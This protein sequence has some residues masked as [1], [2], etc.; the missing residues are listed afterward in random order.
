LCGVDCVVFVG[1]VVDVGEAL[2]AV[3]VGAAGR[4]CEILDVGMQYGAVSVSEDRRECWLVVR[5]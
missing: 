5:M 4:E 1:I 2:A 3:E